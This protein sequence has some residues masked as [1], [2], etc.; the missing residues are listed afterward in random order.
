MNARPTHVTPH[1]LIAT[2]LLLVLLLGPMIALTVARENPTVSR[3]FDG[4]QLF[5]FYGIVLGGGVML[6]KWLL[7]QHW[8]KAS[9]FLSRHQRD[10]H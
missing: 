8:Y 5:A 10:R 6:E 7:R 9:W 4:P 1:A 2:S 3:L